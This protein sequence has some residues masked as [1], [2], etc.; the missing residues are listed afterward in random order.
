MLDKIKETMF[1]I[2]SVTESLGHKI[3]SND[4]YI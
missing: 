4:Y 2:E 1:Y 3:N